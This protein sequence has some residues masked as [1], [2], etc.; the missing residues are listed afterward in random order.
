[1][2]PS[3]DGDWRSEPGNLKVYPEEELLQWESPAQMSRDPVSDGRFLFTN[4]T[5]PSIHGEV[6]LVGAQV[7]A[8]DSCAQAA[9]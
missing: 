7:S 8:V 1:M 4:G 3:G 6:V 5:D 9:C 2:G